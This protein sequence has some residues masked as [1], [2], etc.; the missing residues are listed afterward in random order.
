MNCWNLYIQWIL[1]AFVV[2]TNLCTSV[3][4]FKLQYNVKL[5][6]PTAEA[7]PMTRLKKSITIADCQ[8]MKNLQ[9]YRTIAAEHY[10][11]A[12]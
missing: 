8:R 10:N 4:P 2:H 3:S 5:Q 12:I 6:L 1:F 7:S 11:V 9:K